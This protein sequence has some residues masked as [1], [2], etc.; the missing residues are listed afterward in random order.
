MVSIP[1]DFLKINEDVLIWGAPVELFCEIA[2]K[3]RDRSPFPHTFFYGLNNGYM[4]YL[5]T[6][7]AF[8]EGGHE[9]Q[10]TPYTEQAEEDFTGG[11]L[12]YI[13]SLPRRR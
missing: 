3:I 7:A 2:M 11:V 5:T 1:V 12:S 13:W 10:Q 4:S 8:V 9:V 6:R